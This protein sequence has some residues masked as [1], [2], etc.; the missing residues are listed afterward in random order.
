MVLVAPHSIKPFF[1]GLMINET[2]IM[3][4]DEERRG[5]RHAGS[6]W[7]HRMSPSTGLAEAATLSDEPP[8]A[9]GAEMNG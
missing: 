2:A 8:E 3:G 6:N 7:N 5:L 1:I 9:A 4:E